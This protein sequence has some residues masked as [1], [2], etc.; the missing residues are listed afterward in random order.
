MLHDKVRVTSRGRYFWN[1]KEHRPALNLRVD[2]VP[3]LTQLVHLLLVPVQVKVA[4]VVRFEHAVADSPGLLELVLQV[5]ENL[6]LV[7]NLCPPLLWKRK[8]EGSTLDK[9]HPRSGTES[10]GTWLTGLMSTNS[11]VL[12]S[13]KLSGRTF[14]KSVGSNPSMYVNV[15]KSSS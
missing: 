1:L 6:P 4:L 15:A 7:V 3:P 5:M 11:D 8:K 14:D 13:G 9:H 2:T 12:Q 10:P